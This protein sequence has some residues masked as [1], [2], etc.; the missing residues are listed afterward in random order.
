MAPEGRGGAQ[1]ERERAGGRR[2]VS[3]G[4]LDSSGGQAYSLRVEIKVEIGKQG[5]RQTQVT[6]THCG[7]GFWAPR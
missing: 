3:A 5:T 2:H 1:A 7:Y 6:P 4:K